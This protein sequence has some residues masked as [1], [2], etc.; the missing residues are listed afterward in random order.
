[1]ERQVRAQPSILRIDLIRGAAVDGVELL[2]DLVHLVDVRLV[3]LVVLF[4][5]ARADAVELAD[6]GERLRGQVLP[7]HGE[8]PAQ[9]GRKSRE[10]EA[11]RE[12]A[13]TPEA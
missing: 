2:L 1:R 12:S 10:R 3:Q 8:P 7:W 9:P 6:R 11:A 13:G 4:H 5:R